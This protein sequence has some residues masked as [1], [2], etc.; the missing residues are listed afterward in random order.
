MTWTSSGSPP[1]PTAGSVGTGAAAAALAG[2]LRELGWPHGGAIAILQ[3]DDMGTPAEISPE[4]GSGI[5]V[6]G[7]ARRIA[8]PPSAA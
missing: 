4:P 6:S 5:R 7:D 2:Y 1:S 8:P 3:G